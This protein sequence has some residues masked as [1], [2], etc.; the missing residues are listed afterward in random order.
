MLTGII[1]GLVLVIV[2]SII[3]EVRVI[4]ERQAQAQLLKSFEIKCEENSKLEK[5]YK[6]LQTISKQM[7]NDSHEL[8]HDY[9]IIAGLL[10]KE[11]GREESWKRYTEKKNEKPKDINE[12]IAEIKARKGE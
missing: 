10:E 2:A 4:K 6:E 12:L 11:I 8:V 9:M 3:T 5:E 1:I 7:V